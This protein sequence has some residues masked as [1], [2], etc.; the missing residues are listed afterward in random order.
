MWPCAKAP[1]GCSSNALQALLLSLYQAEILHQE[2]ALAEP[3]LLQQPMQ[4]FIPSRLPYT[5]M[6]AKYA[7][8]EKFMWL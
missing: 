6:Q 2:S 7:L 5:G 3:S 1:A 4:L 8:H